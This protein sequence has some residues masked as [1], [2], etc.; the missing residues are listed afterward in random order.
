M[1]FTFGIITSGDIS[2]KVI[3]SIY[4]QQIPEFEIVV[5]GGKSLWVK[6]KD[7]P[8]WMEDKN[9]IHIPFDETIKKGWITKKKNLITQQAKY[10]NIVFM[11]DYIYLE[12]NWYEGFQDFGED[13]DICM[14]I[15]YNSDG[16]RF[17]DWVVYDDPDLNWPGGGYPQIH[18]NKGHQM[19]LP[20]YDYNKYQYM[21]ISGTYW[22]AK[23]NIM[24]KHPL[25][26]NLLWGQGE[27]A[28][29][30]KR[31]LNQYKYKMNQLSSVKSLKM[32]NLSALNI[33]K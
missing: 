14:N 17:R 32:K 19:I 12:D 18:G 6:G 5:V 31:V 24:K 16:T 30:S 1:K 10:E 7:Y 20:S 23:Q 21:T 33:S 29:W 28:E 27:D 11:H 4:N 3:D 15:I 9:I 25:N 8:E 13:W 22:V 26:E 2:H